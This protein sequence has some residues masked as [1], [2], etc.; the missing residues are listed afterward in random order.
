MTFSRAAVLIGMSLAIG[1]AMDLSVAAPARAKT[2]IQGGYVSGKAYLDMPNLRKIAYVTG[3]LEGMFMAPKLGGDPARLRWLALCTDSLGRRGVRD[4]IEAY[5]VE[6]NRTWN[7]RNPAKMY[8]AIAAGCR[9][10]MKPR[11]AARETRRDGG[12]ITGS[13]YLAMNGLRKKAYVAGLVEGVLLA[14]AFGVDA[15]TIQPF[16]ECVDRLN[17]Q[18]IRRAV[19]ARLLANAQLWP[20][21]DPATR[22]RAII[23]GCGMGR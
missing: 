2:V 12:Y 9:A 23:I 3:L 13:E 20:Q 21:R 11:S 5:L 19:N 14:P 4:I 17:W 18:G 22:Y 7:N 10:G 6:R 1:L 8:R 16:V 15:G